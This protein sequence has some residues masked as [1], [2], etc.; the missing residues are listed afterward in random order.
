MT[1]SL[2]AAAY[3]ALAAMWVA[4][5]WFLLLQG[6]FHTR[7]ARY[8]RETTFVDGP[9]GLLMVAVFLALA[10]IALALL[11]NAVWG[12]RPLLQAATAAVV[13]LLPII[14]VWTG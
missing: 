3:G 14:Y 9:L 11:V 6:G 10:A 4:A 5:A 7:Q 2:K 8:S 13:V 12:R 1:R